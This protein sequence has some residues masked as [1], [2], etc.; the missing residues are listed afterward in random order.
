MIGPR[1]FTTLV[2]GLLVLG[3]CFGGCSVWACGKACNTYEVRIER[4]EDR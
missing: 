2:V 1:E 3:A 4:K